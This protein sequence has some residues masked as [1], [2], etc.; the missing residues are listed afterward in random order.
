MPAV[1]ARFHELRQPKEQCVA[2]L[3]EVEIDEIEVRVVAV[4]PVVDLEGEAA[5]DRRGFRVLEREGQHWSIL[6]KLG[7]RHIVL[8]NESQVKKKID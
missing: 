3:L 2:I 1:D 8:K 7:S 6:P 5:A 4:P